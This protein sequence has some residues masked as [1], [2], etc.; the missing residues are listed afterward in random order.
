[1][2]PSCDNTMTGDSLVAFVAAADGAT[3]L[4]A[5]VGVAG[6]H[7]LFCRTVHVVALSVP[8]LAVVNDALLVNILLL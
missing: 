7:V 1:M 2:T 6:L 8:R 4:L 5:A 3:A